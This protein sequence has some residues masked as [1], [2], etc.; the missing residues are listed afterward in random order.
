MSAI[1]AANLRLL[2]QFNWRAALFVGLPFGLVLAWLVSKLVLRGTGLKPHYE[3]LGC[4]APDSPCPCGRG[5]PYAACCR[6]ADVQ[7]LETDVLAYLTGKWSRSSYRGRRRISSMSNRLQENPLPTVVLP[8]WVS[9]PK[10]YSFPIPDEQL[11]EWTPDRK[12]AAPRRNTRPRRR[13]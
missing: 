10:L 8:G 4:H 12:K 13:R 5:Q 11:Q 7:R 3:R 6:P 1:A 9:D 2:A